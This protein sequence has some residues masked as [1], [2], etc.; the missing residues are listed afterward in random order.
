VL[1]RFTAADFTP[2]RATVEDAETARWINGMPVDD[3]ESMV[4]LAERERRKGAMTRQTTRISARS[5]SS[6]APTAEERSRMRWLLLP[7][8]VASLRRP[9]G[10]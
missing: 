4:R 7:A 2:A 9:Y 6:R 3:A 8:A 1:R 5:C 10:F